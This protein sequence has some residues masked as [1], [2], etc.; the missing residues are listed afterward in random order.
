MIKNIFFSCYYMLGKKVAIVLIGKK[1]SNNMIG[2][3]GGIEKELKKM[4]P[5]VFV[6]SKLEK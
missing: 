5:G 2:K 4:M 6:K 3:K 1:S